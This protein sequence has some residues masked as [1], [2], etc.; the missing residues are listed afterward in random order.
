MALKEESSEV[1]TESSSTGL[2]KQSPE[3]I[4]DEELSLSETQQNS[5]AMLNYLA[6]LTE[7]INTSKNNRL[8]LEA[9]YKSLYNNTSPNAVDDR[10]L[11]ELEGMLDTLEKYRMINVKRERLAYIYEQNQAQAI[12]SAIPNPLGLLSAV[13]SGDLVKLAASVAY[14]AVD[15][16]T[17]YQSA[18][19]EAS[20][21]YLTDGWELDDEEAAALHQRRKDMF[22]YMVRTVQDYGL[23]GDQA[24]SEENVEQL[25]QWQSN[26]NVVRRIQ[27]LESNKAT[28]QGYGGYWLTLA[29]SY[30]DQG[31]YQDCLDAIASYEDMQT[32]IFRKDKDYAK[33]MPL[34]IASAS[35]VLSG[36][37]YVKYADERVSKL[38]ANCNKD[39]WELRYFAAQTYVDLYGKAGGGD[40]L[41]KAYDIAL[42][43][44]NYLV[45]NQRTL[46]NDYLAEIKEAQEKDGMTKEQKEE[47]KQYN[48]MLNEVRKSELP[49]VYQPLLVNCDLLFALAD[50]L[51]VSDSERSKIDGMLHQG[52]ER[53]FLTKALDDKYRFGDKSGDWSD[54]VVSIEDGGKKI[55]LPAELVNQLTVVE[56]KTSSADGNI[57]GEWSAIEVKRENKDEFGTFKAIYENRDAGGSYVDG[58]TVT[59][60]LTDADASMTR[61]YEFRVTVEPRPLFIPDAI[62]F[63]PIS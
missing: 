33:V 4:Q 60:T 42:N 37:E 23:P 27:F 19:N 1:A 29:A 56:V 51:K 15:S 50:E 14:M 53:I 52:G 49:P 11:N 34:A 61:T 40:Y 55:A 62:S 45:D 26:D 24:L 39:D 8:S 2:S 58:D 25:V 18:T 46:N 7:Q 3:S 47:V 54:G 16:Y 21:Q 28:Y 35:E 31:R 9:I 44:V 5:M 22:V 6:V 10:T 59:V 63:E 48:K 17:S 13:Q 43:N 12:R 30:Y 57:P 41:N 20:L 32:G 36:N 38:L